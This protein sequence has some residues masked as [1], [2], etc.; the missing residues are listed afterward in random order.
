MARILNGSDASVDTKMQN[1]ITQWLT[2][3]AAVQ[4]KYAELAPE[5]RITKTTWF[6][7]KHDECS[8]SAGMR[9]MGVAD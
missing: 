6:I 8:S 5:N 1:D 2:K 9:Q 3:N 4:K 7:R